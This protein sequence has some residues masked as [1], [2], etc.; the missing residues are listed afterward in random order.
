MFKLSKRSDYGLVFLFHLA[1]KRKQSPIAL[2]EISKEKKLP[3][4]FLAQI[5]L[6][7]KN[8]GIVRSKEGLGGGYFLDKDPSDITLFEILEALEG[9]FSTTVCQ[10]SPGKCPVENTC[11]SKNPLL[12]ISVQIQDQLKE[13]TLADLVREVN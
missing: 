2:S 11:P 4:N 10:L 3:L 1:L 6:A 7:L 9:P 5:A 12:G 8:V 13:K